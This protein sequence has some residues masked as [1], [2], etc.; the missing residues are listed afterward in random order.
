MKRKKKNKGVNRIL[1][2]VAVFLFLL[3]THILINFE[4]ICHL[5]NWNSYD[6]VTATVTKKT[7]DLYLLLVPVVEVQYTYGDKEYTER[8]F[9]VVQKKFWTFGYRGQSVGDVCK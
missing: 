7:T 3:L 4:G 1:R 9:F 2:L 8:K 6:T 5:S